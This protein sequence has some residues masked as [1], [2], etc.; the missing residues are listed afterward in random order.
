MKLTDGVELFARHHRCLLGGQNSESAASA[1]EPFN[2]DSLRWIW[3]SC[4]RRR[5]VRNRIAPEDG[6]DKSAMLRRAE[7][8]RMLIYASESVNVLLCKMTLT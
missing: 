6:Q 8:A 4:G 1:D 2:H 7:G 3:S 5:K